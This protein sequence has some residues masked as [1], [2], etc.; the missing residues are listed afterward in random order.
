MATDVEV[1]K[2]KIYSAVVRRHVELMGEINI[3][4]RI[5]KLFF[6]DQ[7]MNDLAEYLNDEIVRLNKIFGLAVKMLGERYKLAEE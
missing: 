2:K 3:K 7:G 4:L 1:P 5:M 6:R